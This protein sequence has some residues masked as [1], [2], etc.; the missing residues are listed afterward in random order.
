MSEAQPFPGWRAAIP[1][2][3]CALVIANP[4]S[5]VGDIALGNRV[6]GFFGVISYPLYLWHW[7]LFAFAHI[8]PG[9]IPTPGVMFALA[10]VAVGLAAAHLSLDRGAGG[11][12]VSSPPLRAR[13]RRSSPRWRRPGSSGASHTTR[14]AFPAAF[15]RW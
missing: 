3:G 15:R 14:R 7:P 9:V 8:W 10:V 5:L 6:A 12:P 1:T 4:R 2:A 11:G 13:A